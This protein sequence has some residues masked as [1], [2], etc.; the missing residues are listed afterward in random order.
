MKLSTGSAIFI[1]TGVDVGQADDHLLGAGS[2]EVV[3]AITP[4]RDGIATEHPSQL[5]NATKLEELHGL[6]SWREA[7]TRCYC[8]GTGC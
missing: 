2:K 7:K 5:H 4:D 1:R 3:A 8:S 6:P